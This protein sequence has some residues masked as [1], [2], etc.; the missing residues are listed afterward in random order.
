MRDHCVFDS[1]NKIDIVIAEVKRGR[2]NL[3]GPW[4]TPSKQN[5]HRVLYAVGAFPKSTVPSVAEA[6]YDNGYFE[7]EQFRLRLFA[8]GNEKNDSLPKTTVQLTW[9]EVLDFIYRRF[10]EYRRHKA[11]HDQWDTE[12]KRLYQLSTE[13]SREKFIYA[14]KEAME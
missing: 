10:S 2:C 8:I 11:Q 9:D 7:D 4:T 5:M 12:G 14:I 1:D 13:L 6:M 3:N